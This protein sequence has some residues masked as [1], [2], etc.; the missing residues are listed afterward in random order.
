[1]ALC[2]SYTFQLLSALNDSHDSLMQC[3]DPNLIH[4]H[5]D[6][7]FQVCPIFPFPSYLLKNYL[8]SP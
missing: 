7:V 2:E 3:I 8:G 1:M 6:S 5:A 4:Y